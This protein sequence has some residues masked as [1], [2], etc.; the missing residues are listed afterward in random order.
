MFVLLPGF[1]IGG[2]NDHL[3]PEQTVDSCYKQLMEQVN[4]VNYLNENQASETIADLFDW[5]RLAQQILQKEWTELQSNEQNNFIDALKLSI[6]DKL[7]SELKKYDNGHL[8]VLKLD[9]QKSKPNFA[10]L[11]YSISNSDDSQEFTIYMLKYP[12]GKWKVSN[13]KSDKESLLRYYYGFCDKLLNDYSFEYMVAE[14]SNKGYVVL[15]D[16]ESSQ[17]GQ[18]PRGWTWKDSDNDKH[19]PY[20]VKEENS[21]KYLAAE[22]NGE[23]VI[24]GK[25]VKWN[26]NKYPYVSFRWRAHKLPKGGD[27]RYG[28]T[29]DSAAGNYFIYQKK[30]IWIPESVKYVWSTTL[31]VGSAMR[32]SGTGRP[33]MIVAES[34]TEHLNEWRTYVFDLREAYKK[35]FGGD[36]P[37]KPIGIG[38]LSDANS[39]HSQ[40]YA[41]YDDIRALRHADADSGVKQFLE[42]E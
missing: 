2:G 39:T 19:K 1:L 27:E 14:L 17:V 29:V 15:E 38:I 41:D 7:V 9:N 21:N 11:N 28:N 42:A 33:W 6:S 37:D 20:E 36:P 5:N 40:A 34:G 25:D 16:F 32:R 23:S 31:P 3:T 10:E 12:D 8:P 13:L 24:L 4:N 30:L 26:L 18:L 35:T 22:D